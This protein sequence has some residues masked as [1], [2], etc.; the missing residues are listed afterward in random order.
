MPVGWVHLC[1][2]RQ[3]HDHSLTILTIAFFYPGEVLAARSWDDFLALCLRTLEANPA[4]EAVAEVFRVTSFG[5]PDEQRFDR[6]IGM[7]VLR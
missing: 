3:C 2:V 1:G 5:Y 4:E 7:R 6:L